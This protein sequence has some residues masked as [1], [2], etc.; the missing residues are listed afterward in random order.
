[1]A[2][3]Y[4]E[5]RRRANVAYQIQKAFW[6]YPWRDALEYA[7]RVGCLARSRPKGETTTEE[8]QARLDGLMH[9]LSWR[10]LNPSVLMQ[11][12]LVQVTAH[13]RFAPQQWG[14]AYTDFVECFVS[15]FLVMQ[16]RETG[17]V[18][19]LTAL[20]RL[21]NQWDNH[22]GYIKNQPVS[23]AAILS[24]GPGERG[25]LVLNCLRCF[26]EDKLEGLVRLLQHE[27]KGYFADDHQR[28]WQDTETLTFNG[29]EFEFTSNGT[30]T[31]GS[32][33]LISYQRR[34]Q[35]RKR[36]RSHSSSVARRAPPPSGM[37][38]MFRSMLTSVPL[39][40]KSLW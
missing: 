30:Y 7:E 36:A 39:S 19:C 38:A 26:F 20:E 11:A 31:K 3:S 25:L 29:Q 23:I 14:E 2:D 21:L 9:H 10:G 8:E 40:V 16:Y 15:D 24:G 18:A 33:L 37:G 6:F 13:A 5:E 4:Q 28:T 35:E 22:Y 17:R 34:C 27:E 32:P 1:M 12:L